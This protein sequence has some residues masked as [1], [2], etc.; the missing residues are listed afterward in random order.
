[1]PA[2]RGQNAGSEDQP[3]DPSRARVGHVGVPLGSQHHTLACRTAGSGLCCVLLDPGV[4]PA[5]EAGEADE[6]EAVLALWHSRDPGGVKR[7][8]QGNGHV[9]EID[10]ADSHAVQCSRE[11]EVGGVQPEASG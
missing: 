2:H 3:R 1:M 5:D 10:A 4:A 6:V 9:P 8:R 11:V 7:R